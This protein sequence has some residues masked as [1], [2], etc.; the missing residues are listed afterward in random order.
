MGNRYWWHA[1]EKDSEFDKKY[2]ETLLRAAKVGDVE[3]MREVGKIYLKGEG[4]EK[5]IDEGMKWLQRA[6]DNGNVETL[7]VMGNHFASQD[8]NKAI[9][10]LTKAVNLGNMKAMKNFTYLY[11]QSGDYNKVTYWLEKCA[12]LGNLDS[13]S[14]LAKI[15]RKALNVPK[16][17]L[18]ALEFHIKLA[19]IYGLSS[20]D[21]KFVTK[22]YNMYYKFTDKKILKYYRTTEKLGQ[23]NAMFGIAAKLYETD[24]LRALKWYKMAADAG[25]YDA[26][27]AMAY[28]ISNDEVVP[29][30]V[31]SSH[32]HEALYWYEQAAEFGNINAA[33]N[34][35]MLY[36]DGY[37]SHLPNREKSMYWLEKVLEMEGGNKNI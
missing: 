34:L 17:E 32:Y 37:G 26:A 21:I 22:I 5:N 1:D 29:S 36:H 23:F 35:V 24:R 31:Y 6:A 16:N 18:K 10:L 4:V 13:L 27:V 8:K 20:D 3:S 30:S 33:K 15:Y 12:E 9:D 28:I 11:E 25:D 7:I 19:E 2:Y 14:R